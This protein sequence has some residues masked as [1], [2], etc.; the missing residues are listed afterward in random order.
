[1]RRFRFWSW[2]FYRCFV[3]LCPFLYRSIFVFGSW[4]CSFFCS[5]TFCTLL[6]EIP[7]L[8]TVAADGIFVKDRITVFIG[9]NLFVPQFDLFSTYWTL[10][11][12]ILLS[13][14]EQNLQQNHYKIK[15]C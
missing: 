10:H 13:L 3:R 9:A 1:I 5:G 14:V 11:K 2:F 15:R 12:S 8:F 7:L 6:I 4:L